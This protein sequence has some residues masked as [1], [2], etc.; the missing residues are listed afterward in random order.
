MRWHA[1]EVEAVLGELG[2][3]RAA[4]LSREEVQARLE[5]HGA[6]VLAESGGRNP[7]LILAAQFANALVLILV[8]AAVV[9]L[10]LGDV[11]DA[12]AILVIVVLNALLGFREEYGAEK[13]MASLKAMAAPDVRVRRSGE[14][15]EVPAASLVPG[16]VMLLEAGDLVMADGR[17]LESA[18][19]RAEEAA[20]T[21]ESEAVGKSARAVADAGAA[22]G[23]RRSMVYRGTTVAYG[24][25]VAVVTA[26]GMQTEI[27]AVAGMLQETEEEKTP[28]ARKLDALGLRLALVALALIALVAGIG[29]AQGGS[30]KA[31]FLI[32]V[33]M[34]VAAV[35]EGLPAVVTICLALG[36][37]RMLARRALIRRLPAVETLGAVTT[38]CSDKTGTLTQNRMTLTR[39]R[40]PG[41]TI[42]LDP[43]AAGPLLPE[44]APAGARLLVAAGAL[45][46]DAI[47][48]EAEGRGSAEGEGP[49]EAE[50]DGGPGTGGRVV[51][52]D[53]TEG[54]LVVAAWRAGLAKADLETA[55]PRIA[56]APFDSD[57]KRMSTAHRLP[58]TASG[59]GVAAPVLEAL[60]ADGARGSVAVFAKGAADSLLSVSTHV[61]RGDRVE[62][63][64]EAA[65]EELAALAEAMAAEGIRVLA[66]ACR[67]AGELP[68]EPA[69]EDLERDLVLLGFVG[70]TDPLREAVPDAI[71]TCRRA[72]IRPVMITGDHPLMARHI[73][74]A[75]G[76]VGAEDPVLTGPDL[77]ERDAEA[78]R[79]VVS[80][81]SVYARVSPAHKLRLVD[82]LQANGGIVAMTG[83][84]VNDAPALKSADIGVAMGITGTD[85][86]KEASDMVLLDD[87][88]ATIVAA[89]E[90][91]RVIYDNIR[92][93]VRFILSCNAGELLTMLLAPL[94]GM[95]LPLLPVQILWMN[96]VTDGLP[97]LALGVEPAEPGVMDRPPRNPRAPVLSRAM[98]VRI[99]WVGLLMAA[100]SLGLGYTEW[101]MEG[102]AGEASHTIDPPADAVAGAVG[103]EG[104]GAE[105]GEGAHAAAVEPA[106]WQTTLFTTMVF[107]QLFLAVAERSTRHS[108]FRVGFFRNRALL[109]AVAASVGLQLALIYVPFLQG[110]FGT[111]PLTPVQ[112]LVCF[113]VGL[114]LFVAVEVAK[115]IHRL[116]GGAAEA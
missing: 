86:S 108:V 103:M 106:P 54:A 109:G 48:R 59:A 83:D 17:V 33:S 72:G 90:E 32:A 61:R 45:A 60:G 113:V 21:G 57:R 105:A 5:A 12:V 51:L 9:S 81:A 58:A 80:E 75:L 88:F 98:I 14:V 2:S 42:D 13:A 71:G 41:E 97:A 62:S 15:R 63:L 55:L 64:D 67:V 53:P 110:F 95:P 50:A 102:G 18:S 24:R 84:G 28:L 25:G 85:V 93:F 30:W 87:D 78:L 116:R 39:L 22:L 52:G 36:A 107:A 49:A 65:R 40:L 44:R 23:D 26:T 35:P 100:V 91:G 73:G 29:L 74:R 111:V 27:G 66:V 101:R 99:V 69:A 10:A 6:N 46:S 19:L 34:A 20:L 47:L 31:V 37:Q 70:M 1:A 115:L 43:H 8:A 11:K 68:E 96:L 104:A 4:G 94:F 38:I 77:A 114:S 89:V 79:P 56:E 16:D 112:L 76:I 92:R 3:D 7:W 82:A